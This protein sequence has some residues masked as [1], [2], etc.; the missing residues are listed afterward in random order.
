MSSSQSTFSLEEY[1]IQREYRE[2]KR[3][4]YLRRFQLLKQKV[5]INNGSM[6]V[7][8]KV[9]SQQQQQ[10]KKQTSSVKKVVKP[11]YQQKQL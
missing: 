3:K 4:E 1:K 5:P 9:D 2:N 8:E 11:Q 6:L 10:P 7:G